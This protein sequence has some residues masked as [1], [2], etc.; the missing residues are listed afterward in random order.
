MRRLDRSTIVLCLCLVLLLSLSHRA[1]GEGDLIQVRA[2]VHVHTRFS[3][4]DL[5]LDQVVE[6]AR[7]QGLEAVIFTENLLLRFEYGLFPLRGLVKMAVEKPSLR[8]MGVDRYLQAV[9]AAQ[10]RFPD[11]TLIPGVE[12]VPYYYWV[13]SPRVQGS[14][15]LLFS[16]MAWGRPAPDGSGSAGSGGKALASG[17]R[18]EGKESPLTM[19]DAQKNLLAVGLSRPE[20]YE[21]IPAIGNGGLF[22]RA[23]GALLRLALAV[24]LMSMGVCL[25]RVKRQ[26]RIRLRH[27]TVK[28]QRRYRLPGA[29][30]SGAGV[31]L[32]LDGF[33]SKDLNPY[34]GDLGM[35]PYQRVIEYVESRGGSV[36][37]SFPEA[38]DFERFD[39]GRLGTVL[40][41]TDPYPDA[42]LQ[43]QGYT[44]F[45][46]IY[47]DTVTFT[48]P[49]RQWDTLLLEYTQG[50]RMRPAWGIGEVGYHGPPKPL[51]EAITVFLVP[52]R[53]PTAIL[54]ALKAGHMYAVRPLPEYHLILEDFSLRRSGAGAWVRMG[55][56]LEADG[57]V[58]ILIKLRISSSD[59]REVPVTLRLVRSGEISEVFHGTTPFERTLA[60]KPPGA[61][62]RE[63]FR[64]EVVRPHQL[65]S[66]PIFVQNPG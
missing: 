63:F 55:E 45:G 16:R 41:R 8:Q 54:S 42:L 29:I 37:W 40:V 44:G 23:P 1:W 12:I 43:S 11:V 38:R 47:P 24:L 25:W 35:T 53:S 21:G 50:R 31:I 9:A 15:S 30:A 57:R 33:A 22:P 18:T 5:P 61:G 6:E 7:R 60:V 17:E 58:E 2:A 14:I 32:L 62:R 36:L 27:F 52:E 34:R 51:N 65:L 64:L 59:G 19:W 66:N 13:G 28:V 20:D 10:R 3:T 56:E 26:R 4:G 49:G 48:E 39:L 46:A